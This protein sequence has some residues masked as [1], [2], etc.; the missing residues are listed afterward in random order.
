MLVVDLNARSLLGVGTGTKKAA[1][2]K[3]RAAIKYNDK[4]K[5]G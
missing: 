5:N 2:T 3:R 4:K 1:P